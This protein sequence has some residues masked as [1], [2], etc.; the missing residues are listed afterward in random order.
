MP[1]PPPTCPACPRGGCAG[2]ARGRLSPALTPGTSGHL[3]EDLSETS[4]VVLVAASFVSF[5]SPKCRFSA[6]TAP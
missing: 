3:P 6:D 4:V 2:R 1:A 5:L